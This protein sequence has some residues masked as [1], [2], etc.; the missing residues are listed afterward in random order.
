[1]VAAVETMA[2]KGETPWHGLGFE[3]KQNMTPTQMVKAA[4]IDWT[5]SKRPLS[6]KGKTN[7]TMT[8]LPADFALVRDSDE[9]CLD[10]VGS[11]YR[12]VQNEDAFDFF[13]QFTDAGKMTMETA[14]SLWGGKY[15]WGLARIGKDFKVGGAKSKDDVRTYLLL[16]NAHQHGKANAI[17]FTP[18]RVVCWNTLTMA[19]GSNLKGKPGQSVF[20]MP[21]VRDFDESVKN[22]A[23]ISLGMAIEQAEE[24]KEAANHLAK[25]KINPKDTDE[26]F[27]EVLKYDPKKAEKDGKTKKDGEVKV[28]RMLPKFQAALTHAPG[29]EMPS[30][31]GT[32][33][34]AFNAVTYAIDHEASS[35]GDDTKLK[36]IWLGNLASVKNRALDLALARAK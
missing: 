11:V 15:V 9:Q 27:F 4:Q 5:V 26:Y 3:V 6:F 35:R 1:M 28:P 32:L 8:E 14:G 22:A 33:W 16:T 25:F 10:I 17:A 31:L 19:L 20:R 7:G 18:I 23:K 24:F 12:P 2:W 36:N 21:H 13:K 29:Q 30:A 34:G